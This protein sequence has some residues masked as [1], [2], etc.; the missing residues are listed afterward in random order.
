MKINKLN[1]RG[2]DVKLPG[3][4]R[5]PCGKFFFAEGRKGP[6]NGFLPQKLPF[7]SLYMHEL[8]SYK[9]GHASEECLLLF[10]FTGLVSSERSRHN[11]CP[12]LF[13]SPLPELLSWMFDIPRFVSLDFPLA[14]MSIVTRTDYRAFRRCTFSARFSYNYKRSANLRNDS[15]FEMQVT[16][17]AQLFKYS[18]G[19]FWFRKAPHLDITKWRHPS[20]KPEPLHVSLCD[21]LSSRRLLRRPTCH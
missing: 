21:Q 4:E 19:K 7:L 20:L 18:G 15:W 12:T 16:V 11:Y 8:L 10:S 6:L 3:D 14:L 1:V 9:H 5:P 2:Q 13:V 17:L